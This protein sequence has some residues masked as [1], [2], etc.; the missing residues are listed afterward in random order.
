MHSNIKSKYIFLPIRL[1]LFFNLF[2]LFLFVFGPVNWKISKFDLWLT[3]IY[4][5]INLL[6]LYFGFYFGVKKYRPSFKTC[7]YKINKRKIHIFLTIAVIWFLP[8]IYIRL[9][10]NSLDVSLI[11]D[12]ILTGFINSAE[13]YRN[14]IEILDSS[15]TL[16]SPLNA[17][18]LLV[19]SPFIFAFFP[20]SLVYFKHFNKSF[21]LLII[22]FF[23]IEC[24]SW[25][26]IGTNKGVVDIFLILLFIGIFKNKQINFFD[27]KKILILTISSIIILAYFINNMFSRFGITEGSNIIDNLDFNVLGNPLKTTGVYSEMNIGVKFAL[28]QITSYLSQGYYGLSLAF[29]EPFTWTYGFGNSWTGIAFFRILLKKDLIASTYMGFLE[30]DYGL[31]PYSAWYS[32]YTWLANDFTFWGTPLIVFFI[33][34]GFSYSW[35]DSIYRRNI[36]SIVMFSIFVIEIFYFYA[37]NQVLS[38]SFMTFIVFFLLWIVNRKKIV[39]I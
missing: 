3:T 28:M 25:I 9:G 37:N 26:S 21:K 2:T 18:D 22:L 15:S 1:L 33:G 23:I 32:I 38:F 6:F 12:K 27:L 39:W 8:S 30:K 34:Y 29:K 14:K 20:L 31:D 35:L 13:G 4:V 5:L 36:Y 19:M 10:V 17:F 24:L 7:D 16:D 11:L